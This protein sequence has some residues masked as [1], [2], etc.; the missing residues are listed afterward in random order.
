M[1]ISDRNHKLAQA[2][3]F[4]SA[5]LTVN[6]QGN[7][8]EGQKATLEKNRRGRM[9]SL[10][11][12][13]VMAGLFL[14]GCVGVG[15]ATLFKSGDKTIQLAIMGALGVMLLAMGGGAANFY[16]RSRDVIS[17][18]VSHAE[19]MAKRTSR[20]WRD[21]GV[22][23]GMVYFVKLG[24]KQFRLVSEEQYDAFEEGENYRIY[25][26]KGYPLDVIFS[27]EAF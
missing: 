3:H 18:I 16:L 6:K 27:V 2:F 5:E 9:V 12:F 19:G 15:I 13:A 4:T 26:V 11:A 23:F 21:E 25:Y 10:I 7:I 20:E 17:G 1:S 22:S 24:S 8:A 14:L